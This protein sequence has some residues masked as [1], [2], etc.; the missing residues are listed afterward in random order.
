MY[1]TAGRALLE[2]TGWKRC[3][4]LTLDLELNSAEC[5]YLL[6]D[7]A[8]AEKR[9]AILSTVARGTVNSAAVTCLRINLYATLDQSDR[10]VAVGLEY[11]RQIDGQWSLSATAEDVR[12]EYDRLCQRLR[13]APIDGLLDMPPMRD[14][15]RCATMDVL[16]VLTSSALF[17]D[18]NLLPLI[19]SRMAI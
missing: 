9:L 12:Q 14:P 7:L 10:A 1:F 15:D 4:R 17:T 18:L 11:L 13:S 5:E 3:Y 16:T 8:S 19:V 6:G 2:E